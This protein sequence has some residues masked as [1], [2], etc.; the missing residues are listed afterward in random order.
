MTDARG[1][2]VAPTDPG[3]RGAGSAGALL[4]AG[5]LA[6]LLLNTVGA[7][8]FMLLADRDAESAD[9]IGRTLTAQAIAFGAVVV[10]AL[11]WPRGFPLWGRGRLGASVAGYLAFLLAWVPLSLIA[12]PALWSW[13]GWPIEPQRHLD[14]FRDARAD[15]TFWLAL[16]TVCVIGPLAEEIVFRGYLQTGL[17]RAWGRRSA[18][19]VVAIVF[20]LVHVGS[21]WHV[22]LPIALLGFWFG[23]V[24]ERAEGLAAP[25]V[26]HALHNSLT[27]A[28]VMAFP[29]TFSR[30]YER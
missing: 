11:C 25:F 10:F 19:A 7:A 22:L 4:R 17:V 6:F 16:A 8:A 29:E 2:V 27:V 26:V 1:S 21:G 9:S 13:L 3:S 23:V 30:I 15:A 24:R 12:V 14:F 20:G 28:A 5:V 18:I